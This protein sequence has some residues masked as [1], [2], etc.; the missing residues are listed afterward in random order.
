MYFKV[1][2]VSSSCSSPI[3]INLIH[4]SVDFVLKLEQHST[5]TGTVKKN[6]VSSQGKSH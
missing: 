4:L 1:D 2:Q 6:Q 3:Y 5:N